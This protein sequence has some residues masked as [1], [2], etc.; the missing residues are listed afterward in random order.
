MIH[1]QDYKTDISKYIQKVSSRYNIDN[2]KIKNLIDEI[3]IVID[4]FEFD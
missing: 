3:N 1:L 2:S 4:K